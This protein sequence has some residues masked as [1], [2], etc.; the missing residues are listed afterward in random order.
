MQ[1]IPNITLDGQLNEDFW[2]NAEYVVV[3]KDN[4]LSTGGYYM[5]WG[6][7]LNSYT[8][9]SDAIIK[10]MHKG[11]DLY[12]GV[13]SNDASV[14]KW[15]PGWEADGLFIFMTNYGSIPAA[16]ERM[17]IK[18]MY[19]SGNQGD[20]IEFQL[21]GTVPTGAAEGASFEPT[22]TVTHTETNGP[23]AGYSI[24]TVI[25]TADFGYLVGDTV[26]IS[27]CIWDMDYASVDAYQEGVSDYAPNWWGTQWADPNFEKYF[28]YRGVVLSDQVAIDNEQPLT[29]TDFQLYPNVPNPF[30]PSTTIAFRI[31][32]DSNV[33]LDI[34]NVLGQHVQTLVN[35]Q[36][37]QGYH[38]YVWNG[39]T[40]ENCPA[41]SGI[42]FYKI[43]YGNTSKVAKMVLSK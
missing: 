32:G 34:Y 39:T 37:N 22:G 36:L 15:S 9:R 41:P 19:F 30:N 13:E 20:G 24:E 43:T 25:H 27:I 33:R 10:F 12:I 38:S 18:A 35:T 7:T 11:T 3:G 14:C 6:D 29:V 8:D 5:Q 4:A 26:M 28:M 42:Y 17:E 16:G 23:D 2:A 21:S 31:P 1:L 40:K